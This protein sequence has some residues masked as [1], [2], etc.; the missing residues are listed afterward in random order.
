MPSLQRNEPANLLVRNGEAHLIDVGDGAATRMV[1]AGADFPWLRSIFISHIHF[2]HIGGL[3]G[4]LGLRLQTRTASPLTIYG[5]PGTKQIVDGLIA[6]MRPSAESGFGVPGEVSIP[7]ETNITVVEMTDGA[8]TK[9]GDMTVKAAANTHYS[10]PPGSPEEKR[11]LSLSFRFDLPERSIVYT[12]DTGPSVAVEKLA[13]GADLLVTEMIDTEFTLQNLRRRARH[14]SSAEAD[15]M[16]KH[17]TTHH[18]TTEDIGQL[19]QRAGVKSVVITHLAGGAAPA[20]SATAGYA[21][22]VGRR[23]KGKVVVANDLDRF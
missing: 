9:V 6:A 2:D 7:P 10:F 3:F 13:Q 4:V 12:G 15:Q 20:A 19:A 14:L 16:V 5:P 17:L 23:F 18:L 21:A 22:E 11:F 1:A 8:T